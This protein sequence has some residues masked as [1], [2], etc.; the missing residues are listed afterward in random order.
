[1]EYKLIF[2]FENFSY[3]RHM[4]SLSSFLIFECG[5]IWYSICGFRKKVSTMVGNSSSSYSLERNVDG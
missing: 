5:V 1:M 2:A 4:D 3:A